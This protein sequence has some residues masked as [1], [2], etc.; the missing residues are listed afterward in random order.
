[1]RVRATVA[2]MAEPDDR[3]SLLPLILITLGLVGA[4]ITLLQWTNARSDAGALL[5]DPVNNG[6]YQLALAISAVVL[7]AGVILKTKD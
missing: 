5:A 7:L 6:P 1:M 3:T 2:Q 4:G